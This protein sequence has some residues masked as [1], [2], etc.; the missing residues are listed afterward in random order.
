MI[1][2]GV[3]EDRKDP[4]KLGRCRVRILKHHTAIRG[5]LPT[6]HLPWAYP[7]QPITSAAM[8][9]VGQTPL[10]PVE[11]TWVIGFFRDGN[12][13]QQPV[14][15]GTLAGI[16]EE[17]AD[18]G[19]GFN[20][21]TDPRDKT[22]TKPRFPRKDHLNEPDTNRLARKENLEETI[23]YR[24]EKLLDSDVAIANSSKTFS[25]PD[26]SYHAEYPY[27][28]VYESESGHIFE[29]DDTEG[30]ERLHRY[31]KAGTFEEIRPDGSRVLKIEGKDYTIIIKNKHVHIKG[32]AYV[33][34]DGD[35]REF[36]KGNV[37]REISK[38]LT[39]VIG[40]TV[41]RTIGGNE[42][43]RVGGNYNRA[44]AKNIFVDATS[45][46]MTLRATKKVG[47]GSHD[48]LTLEGKNVTIK[49]GG[50][51][52]IIGGSSF[53]PS[54]FKSNVDTSITS[55]TG[56][57]GDLKSSLPAMQAS[58]IEDTLKPISEAPEFV[59]SKGVEALNET[60]GTEVAKEI[61]EGSPKSYDKLVSAI[62]E[63]DVDALVATGATLDSV[64]AGVDDLLK[65]S[66]AAV[67]NY[68]SSV[69]K[70]TKGKVSDIKNGDVDVLVASGI[71]LKTAQTAVDKFSDISINTIEKK[72]TNTTKSLR[73]D[74]TPSLDNFTIDFDQNVED[75]LLSYRPD[76]GNE[77]KGEMFTSIESAQAS[78]TAKLEPLT[79]QFTDTF[80]SVSGTLNAS[81]TNALG[82]VTNPIDD[83]KTKL[84][85][86]KTQITSSINNTWDFAGS[87]DTHVTGLMHTHAGHTDFTR[88]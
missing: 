10:G 59:K 22:G 49:T 68:T 88:I 67:D 46:M 86:T 36:V 23:L 72:I 9:G 50:E 28:H 76:F 29:V 60:F 71:D 25:E 65:S 4:L 14:F 74:L 35:L 33:T 58:G 18:I 62:A 19:K 30:A 47:I 38:N 7:A 42:E 24:R 44:V 77:L 39:E 57:L 64:Q 3:V 20:A 69:D 82:N 26:S 56:A 17:L 12:E 80:G 27:N 6:Q 5:K 61:R 79:Q 40:G 53:S 51:F 15:F 41:K 78:V 43:V 85:Q 48:D 66:Q 45:G 83:I 11:G 73:E 81:I 21:P 52:N 75:G 37:N 2:Y 55:A 54:G 70:W 63:G 87:L 32:N 8:S 31:H 34:I 84:S 13:A 1:W 16:P